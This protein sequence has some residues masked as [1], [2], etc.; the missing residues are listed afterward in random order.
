MIYLLLPVAVVVVMAV[1]AATEMEM[2]MEM[3]AAMAVAMAMDVREQT[4]VCEIVINNSSG[5]PTTTPSPDKSFGI[6]SG[7][8]YGAHVESSPIS[9]PPRKSPEPP[10]DSNGVPYKDQAEIER[11]EI[12]ARTR[13]AAVGRAG[14]GPIQSSIRN[15]PSRVLSFIAQLI[16]FLYSLVTA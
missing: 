15:L 7:L 10:P 2:E 9:E 12:L 5:T 14:P 1:V 13:L 16:N 8:F 4:C 3:A 6:E 11:L